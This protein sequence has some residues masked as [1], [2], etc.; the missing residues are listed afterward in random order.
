MAPDLP[1]KEPV[2]FARGGRSASEADEQGP[3]GDARLCLPV[4]QRL[5]SHDLARAGE[6]FVGA[7]Q[8]VFVGEPTFRDLVIPSAL[9]KAMARVI[10][11]RV[12]RRKSSYDLIGGVEAMKLA[13]HDEFKGVIDALAVHRH[14]VMPLSVDRQAAP[15]IAQ[16][17]R[18]GGKEGGEDK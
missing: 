3:Q 10:E 4:L 13:S 17:D 9:T 1:F 7:Q 6:S 11:C 16:H 12:F 8:L 14:R 15:E 5:A 18:V 2:R